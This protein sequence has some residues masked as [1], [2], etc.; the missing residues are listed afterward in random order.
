MTDPGRSRQIREV[1][2]RG[3]NTLALEAV[4]LIVDKLANESTRFENMIREGAGDLATA[5]VGEGIVSVALSRTWDIVHGGPD[6]WAALGSGQV[7]KAA[8][9]VNQQRVVLG[10]L[11]SRVQALADSVGCPSYDPYWALL[12]R[13]RE[14]ALALMRMSRANL[15]RVIRFVDQYQGFDQARYRHALDQLLA[16]QGA[17]AETPEGDAARE[18]LDNFLRDWD[19][20]DSFRG[21]LD[22]AEDQPRQRYEALREDFEER[23][24]HL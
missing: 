3:A 11:I 18:W 5:V 13:N 20:L 7:R 1:A 8:A 23:V 2:E 12:I 15:R 16:A 14:T 22:R 6:V 9:Q 21:A 17:L 19:E 4:Q 10:R 24:D